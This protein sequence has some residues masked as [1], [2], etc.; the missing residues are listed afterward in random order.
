MPNVLSFAEVRDGSLRKV[1]FEV[2]TAGR[3]LADQ[4]NGESHVLLATAPGTGGDLAKSLG[5]HGADVVLVCEHAGFAQHN[6]EAARA[7]IAQLV[8]DRGYGVVLLPASS[9]GKD[10]APRV[11]A[12]LGV[13]LASDV[14]SLSVADGVIH[15]KHPV[16]TSK[17][18]ATLKLTGSPAVLSLRPNMFSAEENQRSA[19]VE[20]IAAAGDPSS[21]RTRVTGVSASG[22]GKV[23]LSE[24]PVIVSGGRGL[25]APENFSLVED[26]ARAFGNAAVGCTRAVSDAGWRPHSDQI[27][28]TGRTVSPDLYVAVGISGAIQHIAG[29][30]NSRTIVAINKDKEAPIFKVATTAL[31]AT[32]STL[33]RP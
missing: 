32:C 22:G 1:S 27:G 16:N 15:A 23:D 21:S 4:L 2:A 11:A 18:I 13:G 9:H 7:L 19:K 5:S 31:S 33:C 28:Q 24:A 10:I 30:R 17:V 26:L 3:Y 25:K 14:T 6:P 12:R 29:M 8:R 20:T